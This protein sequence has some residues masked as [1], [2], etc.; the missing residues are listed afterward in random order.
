MLRAEEITDIITRTNI[1]SATMS[2]SSCLE[3]VMVL[4]DLEGIKGNQFAEEVITFLGYS[5]LRKAKPVEKVKRLGVFHD[6]VI[7]TLMTSSDPRT[8]KAVNFDSYWLDGWSNLRQ[9]KGMTDV[10]KEYSLFLREII[11]PLVTMELSSGD[12]LLSEETSSFVRF[13]KRSFRVTRAEL[14]LA[15]KLYLQDRI[16]FNLKNVSPV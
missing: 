3:D 15:K 7:D 11:R 16:L 1:V 13:H 10:Q 9:Y 2:F 12:G 14:A 8:L 4:K 5:H 6:M